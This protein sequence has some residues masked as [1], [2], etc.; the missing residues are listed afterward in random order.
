M[1]RKSFVSSLAAL[2]LSASVAVLGWLV[3]PA[4]PPVTSSSH[5]VAVPEAALPLEPPTR[6][7]ETVE[8]G[9]RD[10][11]LTSLLTNDVPP[12]AAYEIAGALRAAGANLRQVRRGDQLVLS[13]DA[14]D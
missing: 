8:I 14:E 4:R 3:W 5:E 13:R 2:T 10:T 7:T 1:I 6:Q 9:K 11:V 12:A